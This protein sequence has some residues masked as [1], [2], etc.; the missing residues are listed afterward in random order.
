MEMP[1][2]WRL[3]TQRYKLIGD[4][5]K[6]D[7]PAFPPDDV[8]KQCN[9]DEARADAMA[10]SIVTA[11]KEIAE[12]KAKIIIYEANPDKYESFDEI[13]IN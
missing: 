8:C 4:I 2:H 11:K 1:R 3:K 12:V 9:P 10:E 5:C 7:H 13:I 6:N